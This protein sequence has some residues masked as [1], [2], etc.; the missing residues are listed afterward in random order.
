MR[1]A[2]KASRTAITGL[3]ELPDGKQ[4]LKVSVTEVPEAGRATAAVI[5]LLA[6]QWGV[7]KT[8]FSVIAGA[9]DRNKVLLVVGDADLSVR[10][11]N[12][13]PVPS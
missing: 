3:A 13:V 11:E 6:K 10:L 2:P 8:A 4:A 9:T 1:V 7:P 12:C 5:R